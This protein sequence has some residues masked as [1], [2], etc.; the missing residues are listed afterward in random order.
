M[1]S[2][3]LDERR[4]EQSGPTV[5]ADDNASDDEALIIRHRGSPDIGTRLTFPSLRGI[6]TTDLPRIVVAS[7]QTHVANTLTLQSS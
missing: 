4:H 2:S 5:N 1:S 3:K 6:C 7:G